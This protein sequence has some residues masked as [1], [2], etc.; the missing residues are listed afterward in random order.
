M[1]LTLDIL[2][3]PPPPPTL[4]NISQWKLLPSAV[5]PTRIFSATS[6]KNMKIKNERCT[7]HRS[8]SS[9]SY[10]QSIQDIEFKKIEDWDRRSKKQQ[11]FFDTPLPPYTTSLESAFIRYEVPQGFPSQ[12]VPLGWENLTTCLHQPRTDPPASLVIPQSRSFS[13]YAVAATWATY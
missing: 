2:M 4:G 13:V 6:W 5:L 1:G 10:T 11:H 7:E 12:L 9:V 3:D 8:H